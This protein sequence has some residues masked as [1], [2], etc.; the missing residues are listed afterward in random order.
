[1]FKYF[2]LTPDSGK[3]LYF[4]LSSERGHKIIILLKKT[5]LCY[6]VNKKIMNNMTESEKLI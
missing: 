4:S 3:N 6:K 5:F 1:M 2:F